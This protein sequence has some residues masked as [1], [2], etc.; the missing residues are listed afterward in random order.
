M[1]CFIGKS[2]ISV[3]ENFLQNK[4]KNTNYDRFMIDST[5]FIIYYKSNTYEIQ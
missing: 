4:N 5:H 3:L 2:D 1:F